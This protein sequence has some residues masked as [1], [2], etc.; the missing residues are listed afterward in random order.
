[1]SRKRTPRLEVHGHSFIRGPRANRS[2]SRF[3]H[4]HEGGDVPHRHP[5]TGPGSY[6]IDKDEWFRRTGLRGGGRKEFTGE[7]KGE[8][9]A[10]IPLTPEECTFD[11]IVYD[12][13]EGHVGVGGISAIDRV[14]LAFGFR[15]IVIKARDRS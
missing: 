3:E 13:P 10:V 12:V 2:D 1:M 15:P 5:D 4:A 14:S 11:V 8:R 9:L 7:P 6:T